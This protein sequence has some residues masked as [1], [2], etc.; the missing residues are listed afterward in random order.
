MRIE[1]QPDVGIAKAVDRLHRI[2][3]DEQRSAIA[4]C[5]PGGQ[6]FDQVALSERSILIFVDQKMLDSK[7]ERE[8]KLGGSVAARQRPQRDQG[9]FVEIDRADIG[10]HEL[11]PRGYA[12]QHVE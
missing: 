7:V 6:L 1:K 12:R 2:A 11:E 9:R 4:R 8:Q 10:E 5:P 3:D